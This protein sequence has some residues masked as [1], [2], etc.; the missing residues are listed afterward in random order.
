MLKEIQM[1][2][3]RTQYER[4]GKEIDTAISSVLR[5]TTF[6]NNK[7]LWKIKKRKKR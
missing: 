5:S 2:D 4:L 6:I 7:K 3:L 1:V